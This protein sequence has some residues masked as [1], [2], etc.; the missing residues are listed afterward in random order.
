MQSNTQS[1][2]AKAQFEE[3]LKEVKR[4]LAGVK[5][6]VVVLSGKGGVGKSVVAAYL[7]VVLAKRGRKVG[8]LDADFHGPSIPS[9]LGVEGMRPYATVGGIVPVKGPYGIFVMSVALLTDEVDVPVVWRGPLKSGVIREL[10]TKVAWGS[11]DYLIIDLPP[12][13]GDESL[14]I[15]QFLG[16][17]SIAVIVTI[18]SLLSEKVVAR[19]VRFVKMFPVRAAGIVEN[20]TTFYCPDTGKEY[21]LF[22][23]GVADDLSR[24]Y[25][26]EVWARIPF[27]YRIAQCCGTGKVCIDEYPDSPVVK[28]LEKLADE[29]E[30][31]SVR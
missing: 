9:L 29:I 31:R 16:D 21:P 3:I 6:K 23:K 10:L 14:T 13:T 8:I 18:P 27:D 17:E 4:S 25:G 22:G 30:K 19:A 2:Q 7:T 24:R 5:N 20:M 28:A 1:S 12:G 11:L 26:L 15:M